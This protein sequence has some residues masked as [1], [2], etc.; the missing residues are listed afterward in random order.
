MSRDVSWTVSALRDLEGIR[1]YLDQFNP[2]A[3]RLVA[4]RL[5]EAGDSLT[6]FPKRGRLLGRDRVL[7]VVWPYLIR[8]RVLED[9][10]VILRV[11][12]GARYQA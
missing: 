8:Y 5:I 1:A 10:I 3:A 9:R 2:T 6:T 4:A 12:H 7:M 11:R